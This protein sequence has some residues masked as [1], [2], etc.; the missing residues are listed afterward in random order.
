MRGDV[1]VAR[2]PRRQPRG[3]RGP[4]VY[5][6]IKD[7]IRAGALGIEIPVSENEIARR[8][9]VSR[10][11]VR[12]AL[13]RLKS[14]GWLVERDSKGLVVRAL[15]ESEIGEIYILREALEGAAA[16]LATR[17]VSQP[18][19]LALKEVSRTFEEAA[20]R[21][22]D[23]RE[24]E[25]IN[26]RFHALLYRS[27]NSAILGRILE[28]LQMLTRQLPQ[29]I[30]IY[31]SRAKESAGDH[32]AMVAALVDHDERRAE[33]IARA[34]VSRAREVREMIMAES[35]AARQ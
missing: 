3:L 21:G 11:P 15:T 1:A 26:A 24:L 30:F 25:R 18:E 13:L 5:E 8:L 2:V 4:H 22:E 14:E 6:K 28:P 10:T 35:L 16:R 12:E 19:L 20:E 23:P 34:H 9:E 7:L 31:P 27:S 29:S 32:L 17:N 33:D